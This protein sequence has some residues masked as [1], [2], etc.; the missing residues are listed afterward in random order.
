MAQRESS[1]NSGFKF[2]KSR[3]F[4]IGLMGS[5][6]SNAIR[7]WLLRD[8][9]YANVLSLITHGTDLGTRGTLCNHE[10]SCYLNDSDDESAWTG[11]VARMKTLL[12]A[13]LARALCIFH[14]PIKIQAIWIRPRGSDRRKK[15]RI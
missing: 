6:G 10:L 8:L 12:A 13:H 9:F 5:N 1:A 3:Q 2:F 4:G 14:Y 11:L 7:E 15:R